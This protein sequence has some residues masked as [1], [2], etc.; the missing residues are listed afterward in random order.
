[1]CVA[2][3]KSSGLATSTTYREALCREKVERPLSAHGRRHKFGILLQKTS[4]S[5]SQHRW[6]LCYRTH[7]SGFNSTA[8]THISYNLVVEPIT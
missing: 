2:P 7:G 3:N 1:M 5:A 8:T 4:D 6:G